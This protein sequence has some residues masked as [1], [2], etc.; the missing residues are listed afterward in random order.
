MFGGPKNINCKKLREQIYKLKDEV[1]RRWHD[2]Q[3]N[4]LNLPL[5]GRMSIEGH[6]HQLR[7]KQRSLRAD[8]T[9]YD[10]AG[11]GPPPPGAWSWATA[12]TP[13]PRI[14]SQSVNWGSVAKFAGGAAL[15]IGAAAAAAA[16][17]PYQVAFSA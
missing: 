4:K 7:G 6:Q 11:C 8:L 9:V 14:S 15:A 16:S 3:D 10:S 1:R 5:R 12:Y 13:G 17:W 2:L